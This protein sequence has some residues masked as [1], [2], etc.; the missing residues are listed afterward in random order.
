[1]ILKKSEKERR[2]ERKRKKV[3]KER[4]GERRGRGRSKGRCIKWPSGPGSAHRDRLAMKQNI[5]ACAEPITYWAAPAS[6]ISTCTKG[7]DTF[8]EETASSL[9]ITRQF[10]SKVHI[11]METG[12]PWTKGH[13]NGHF[14]GSCWR[15]GL[16]SRITGLGTSLVLQWPILRAPRAGG[17][18]WIWSGNEASHATAEFA[19]TIKTRHS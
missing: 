4:E 12:Y 1:M 17:V 19:C 10:P 8:W 16:L 5:S 14:F 7:P 18:G 11:I 15:E 9:F 2:K 6:N 13:Y 3:E